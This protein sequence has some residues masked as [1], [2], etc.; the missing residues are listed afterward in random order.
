MD[1]SADP[2]EPARGVPGSAGTV[3]WDPGW[4][5]VS[6]P[7]PLP[8]SPPGLPHAADKEHEEQVKRS[9]GRRREA[10]AS[11]TIASSWKNHFGSRLQHGKWKFTLQ[12]ALNYA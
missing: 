12:R 2:G 9:L 1:S 11:G 4:G 7:L 5:A 6:H 8:A 10:H 3:A